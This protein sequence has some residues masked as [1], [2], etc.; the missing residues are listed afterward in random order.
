MPR[1]SHVYDPHPQ[2]SWTDV[3]I[4]DIQRLHK[5][6]ASGLI[7]RVWLVLKTYAWNHR[8][9]FPSIKSIAERMDYDLEKNYI[10]TIGKALRWLEEHGFI[11]RNDRRRHD[12]YT[13]TEPNGSVMTEPNGSQKQTQKNNTQKTPIAPLQVADGDPIIK[14]KKSVIRERRR[15]RRNRRQRLNTCAERIRLE[16]IASEERNQ[17]E[18]EWNSNIEAHRA[19]ILDEMEAIHKEPT[20]HHQSG[21]M[22]QFYASQTLYFHGLLSTLPKPEGT[23]EDFCS[24]VFRNGDSDWLRALPIK[25]MDLPTIRALFSR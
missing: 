25:P 17:A 3:S 2:H 16:A 5:E 21:R 22:R 8:S 12:R 19:S 20:P 13:L 15:N 9:C 7:T 11:Q 10:Q 18:Q 24:F 6:G 14:T 23:W 1:S 4:G